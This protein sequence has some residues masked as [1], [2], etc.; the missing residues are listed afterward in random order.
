M[1]RW[2]QELKTPALKCRRIGHK[3]QI[4]YRNGYVRPTLSRRV[5]D[6]VTQERSVCRRCGL[7]FSEWETV[8][9]DGLQGYSWPSEM[10]N[11][12]DKTG[13][14]WEEIGYRSA[15]KEKE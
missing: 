9:C 5:C 8:R 10:A 14:Y 15:E 11:I 2:L 6:E 3:S 7:I 13:E 4:Q 1:M 12:F